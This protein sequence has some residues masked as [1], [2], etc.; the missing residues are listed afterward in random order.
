[1][2]KRCILIVDDRW[3]NF[4]R[5][6]R[7]QPALNIMIFEY[8]QDFDVSIITFE[9]PYNPSI[10]FSTPTDEGWSS[11]TFHHHNHQRQPQQPHQFPT[12]AIWEI[13]DRRQF[14][15][16]INYHKAEAGTRYRPPPPSNLSS[17]AWRRNSDGNII[18]HPSTTRSISR[19]VAV[20]FFFF[21]SR[22][23]GTRS[24]WKKGFSEERLVSKDFSCRPKPTWSGVWPYQGMKIKSVRRR[25]WRFLSFQTL[26]PKKPRREKRDRRTDMKKKRRRKPLGG[27]TNFIDDLNSL[28]NRGKSRQV[29]SLHALD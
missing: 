8:Y 13:G 4:R 16:F 18:A 21:K 24:Q 1:M 26:S 12:L 19:S 14:T 5:G 10:Q 29:T 28:G 25:E 11:Y 2:I 7:H 23:Q 27:S 17:Q 3:L 9:K 6:R 22:L 20:V 15:V